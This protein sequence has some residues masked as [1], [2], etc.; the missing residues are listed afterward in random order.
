MLSAGWLASGASLRIFGRLHWLLLLVEVG[1]SGGGEAGGLCGPVPGVVYW[2]TLE[3]VLL[4][5]QPRHAI[6]VVDVLTQAEISP[7]C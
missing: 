4:V 5:T 6:D 1:R 2:V 3:L 7:Q